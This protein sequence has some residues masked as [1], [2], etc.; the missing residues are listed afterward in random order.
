VSWL[1][2]LP[3][4]ATLAAVVVLAYSLRRVGDEAQGLQVS[5]LQWE[6]LAVAMGDL[7]HEARRAELDLRRLTRR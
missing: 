4:F 3:A 6:R 2:V 7:D 1:W 5:L